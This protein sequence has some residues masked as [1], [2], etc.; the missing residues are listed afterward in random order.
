MCFEVYFTGANRAL[1]SIST[2]YMLRLFIVTFVF[3]IIIQVKFLKH[4]T[5]VERNC[6]TATTFLFLWTKSN[7][8][9]LKGSSS[10]FKNASSLILQ[11][12]QIFWDFDRIR[13]YRHPFKNA[14]S[15]I[16][17]SF[18]IFWDFDRIREYRHPPDFP[19][20]S[21]KLLIP[22]LSPGWTSC[23]FEYQFTSEIV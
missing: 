22:C 17:Q 3:V 10:S 8:H 20:S 23:N 5:M 18:Q 6:W 11:S 13:E 19:Q 12:F 9:D 14:S 4:K 21:D 1:T 7:K 16:L 15:L 2:S